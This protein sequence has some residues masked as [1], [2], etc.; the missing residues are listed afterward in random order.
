MSF[1]IKE[2]NFRARQ[3]SIFMVE[4]TVWCIK[5]LEIETKVWGKVKLKWGCLSQIEENQ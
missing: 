1:E 2:C 3:S 5:T 4:L